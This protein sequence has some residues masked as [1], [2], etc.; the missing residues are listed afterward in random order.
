MIIPAI[1]DRPPHISLFR[2]GLAIIYKV[3]R[4]L[5]TWIFPALTP[6]SHHQTPD[7]VWRAGK[8]GEKLGPG[9]G[10]PGSGQAQSSVGWRGANISLGREETRDAGLWHTNF[11]QRVSSKSWKMLKTNNVLFV[12][13]CSLV[14]GTAKYLKMVNLLNLQTKFS[15]SHKL[16]FEEL[17]KIYLLIGFWSIFFFVL[18]LGLGFF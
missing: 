5:R 7:G 14:S 13:A 11:L 18:V 12:L 2:V 17:S 9:R 10:K 8:I 3:L 1:F 6:F 16:K 4:T 15:I